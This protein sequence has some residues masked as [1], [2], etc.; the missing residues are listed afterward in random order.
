[1]KLPY[2]AVVMFLTCNVHAAPAVIEVTPMDPLLDEPMTIRISGLKAQQS[3]KIRLSA[4]RNNKVWQAEATFTA[5]ESG[6][7]DLSKIAPSAGSYAGVEPMGLVFSMTP[8][9]EDLP[10]SKPLARTDPRITTCE[11]LIGEE[12]VAKKDFRRFVCR[13]DVKVTEIREQGLVGRLFEPVGGGKRPAVIVLSGSE[14]GISET[15]AMLQASRG[16][17]AFALGYF[18]VEGLPN[19][20]VSI[21]LEYFRTG[22][23]WLKKRESVDPN[24]IGVMG[25]SRGGEL[26]LL[27]GATNPDIKT[28]VATVP[29]HVVWPGLGMTYREPSWTKGGQPLPMVPTVAPAN[30]M[31][32]FMSG[33]PMVL[34][35]L[36]EN[37]LKDEE[38]VKAAAIPVENI[39]GPVLLLSG[40]ADQMWPSAA[41]AEQVVAR[42]KAKNFAHAVEHHSYVDAGHAI[43]PVYVPTRDTVS[44]G[45][46]MLGGT[47]LGNA[48]AIADSRP[49]VLRFLETSFGPKTR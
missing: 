7:V 43:L 3:V 32:R 16:R 46:Y 36:F 42:L 26:A 11:V 34:L 38:K 45:R 22:L 24:R 19:Q 49:N 4:P 25:A 2:L 30:F 40:K 47:P 1:M 23:D 35:D 20:L 17:V 44:G 5:D 10:D 28:V 18:G 27:L 29:S 41:M 8:T 14:G 12:V 9:A 48:K 31:Q 15:E 37:G 13:P 6:A 33:K 39:Q 21:P